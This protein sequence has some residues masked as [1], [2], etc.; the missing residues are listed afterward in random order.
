MKK[1]IDFGSIRQ[2]RD[3]IETI[4][5]RCDFHKLKYPI[6]T[7]VGTEQIHGTNTAVCY[8]NLDGFW[9]QSRKQVLDV[10]K[11]IDNHASAFHANQN[12]ESWLSILN[13]LSTQ[14]E[15][16]LSE[17]TISVYYEWAGKGIQKH[18]ALSGFE[19]T[20]FI[21]RHFKVTPHKE[22]LDVYWLETRKIPRWCSC[23]DVGIYNIMD[24][25]TV[26]IEIDFNNPT[27][28]YEKM[29]EM[30]GE[31]ELNSKVGQ[32]LGV[33]GNTGEG[34]VFTFEFMGC[35]YKFKVKGKKHAG[36]NRVKT[37]KI[38]DVELEQ[39][40]QDFVVE[41]CCTQVRLDQMWNELQ[42]EK[43]GLTIKMLGEFL[44]RV[45][46]DCVKEESL[47]MHDSGFEPKDVN[48]VIS[49]VAKQWFFDMLDEKV[50]L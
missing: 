2:F 29:K 31:L 19:K 44:K 4:K 40:K 14:Y 21:F 45:Q 43:G 50:G 39:R 41:Y 3:V 17:N 18:S 27:I 24:F 7:S 12:K 1:K 46:S 6:I 38:V 30:V 9:V 5:G 36:K 33:E 15:I 37:P 13:E 28:A 8:N 49:M 48:K 34:Y 22:S 20:A 42:Q 26:R 11:A 32:A 25:P 10:E 47:P 16:N 23:E 35:L